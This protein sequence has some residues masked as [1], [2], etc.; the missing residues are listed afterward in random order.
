MPTG[1]QSLQQPWVFPWW[2]Q[3]PISSQ[4]TLSQIPNGF[5]DDCWYF[6]Y[7]RLAQIYFVDISNMTFAVDD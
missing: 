2:S 5:T 4:A 7:D 3:L 6:D 1:Y